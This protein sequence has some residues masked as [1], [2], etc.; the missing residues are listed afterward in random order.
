MKN[1]TEFRN[2]CGI[3]VAFKFN[4]QIVYLVKEAQKFCGDVYFKLLFHIII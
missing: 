1:P 4:L 2:D 3:G